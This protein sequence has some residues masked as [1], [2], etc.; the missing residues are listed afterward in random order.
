MSLPPSFRLTTEEWLKRC[1][2]L[3]ESIGNS[4]QSTSAQTTEMFLLW[5]DK[6]SPRETGKGCGTCVARVWKNLRRNYNAELIAY[7]KEKE[8]NG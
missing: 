1:E 3:I 7:N 5:N 4:G 2:A 6:F 8:D